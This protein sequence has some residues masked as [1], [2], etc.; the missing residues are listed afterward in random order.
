MVRRQNIT[1]DS[2]EANEI[3]KSFFYFY[4]F[5]LTKQE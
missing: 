2:L 5:N 1:T 4:D 3:W